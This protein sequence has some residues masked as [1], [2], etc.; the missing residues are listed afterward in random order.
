MS[1]PNHNQAQLKLPLQCYL[2]LF[3]ITH[4]VYNLHLF[5]VVVSAYLH[6]ECL[7]FSIS[8]PS[9]KEV[10]AQLIHSKDPIIISLPNLINS[11]EIA[12]MMQMIENSDKILTD[13]Y[14]EDVF[15]K[16]AHEEEDIFFRN[17]VQPFKNVIPSEYVDS[18][19]KMFVYT[20]TNF[21]EQLDEKDIIKGANAIQRR[22]AMERW[23]SKEGKSIL[24]MSGDDNCNDND[25]NNSFRSI[26]K[27]YQMPIELISYLEKNM[28]PKI[29][30][31][32]LSP[33]LSWVLRDA[34]IVHYFNGDSQVPHLDPCDATIL[35]C[36]ENNTTDDDNAGNSSGGDTCFPMIDIRISNQ[37]GN[38][39][40]FFSSNSKKSNN[41]RERNT[42][43]LHHGGIVN[44]GE[45]LIF[46]LM[47]DLDGDL[48]DDASWLD[49]VA[50]L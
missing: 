34:T 21:Q 39:L 8:A 14:Q 22:Q 15:S 50:F 24:N 27:R 9:P 38:G 29:L 3:K 33:S 41:G 37:K 4:M 10:K 7:S 5:I 6:L 17:I 35:V 47:L 48:D 1:Y 19:M 26:G 16:T 23:T 32:S 46:Q 45:K 31:G 20:V 42:M 25:D 18:P 30:K 36:L 40:L 11:N 2:F 12:L 43:S 44:G 13:D 49:T 28:L